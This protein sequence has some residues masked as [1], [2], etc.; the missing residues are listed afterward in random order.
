MGADVSVFMFAGIQ[1]AT[2]K[3]ALR[4]IAVGYD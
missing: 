2:P 4:L 1:L 3:Q